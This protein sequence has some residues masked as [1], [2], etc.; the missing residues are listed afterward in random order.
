[1]QHVYIILLPS[2]A[3][4]QVL[5]LFIYFHLFCVV[6]GSVAAAAAALALV[7]IIVFV[8][9]VIVHSSIVHVFCQKLGM[10]VLCYL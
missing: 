1:M 5:F 8:L 4:F 9:I 10:Y 6:G 7:G 3:H 2:T